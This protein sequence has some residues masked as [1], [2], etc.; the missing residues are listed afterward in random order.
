MKVDIRDAFI[1]S[2]QLIIAELHQ[3]V[4]ITL[5][6]NHKSSGSSGSTSSTNNSNKKSL[7]RY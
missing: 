6:V 1:Q 4:H 3:R 5:S 7:S 2:L